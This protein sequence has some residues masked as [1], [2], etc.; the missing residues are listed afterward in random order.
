M[1]AGYFASCVVDKGAQ[2]VA[3]FEWKKERSEEGIKH[4]DGGWNLLLR[5]TENRKEKRVKWWL[6]YG[7]STWRRIEGCG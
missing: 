2:P 7:R 3:C 5:W 6:L 1:D 4:S